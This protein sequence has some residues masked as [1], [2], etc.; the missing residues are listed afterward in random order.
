MWMKDSSENLEGFFYLPLDKING[1]LA[2]TILDKLEA[3]VCIVDIRLLKLIWT[4]KYM[5]KKL[6]YSFDELTSMTSDELLSLFH[7]DFQENL[8]ESI[9]QLN[10]KM[11]SNG[12]SVY[13]IR[14][15]DNHWI[16]IMAT[17]S[18]YENNPDG[19]YHYL[20]ASAN[21]IDIQG[22]NLHLVRLAEKIAL[23]PHEELYKLISVRERKI[24]QL[25]ANGNTDKEIAEVLNI[26]I[27]T[28]KTHRKKIIHKLG[29]KNSRTL[30][31]YAFQNGLD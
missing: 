5:S 18:V 12:P 29:L 27:H 4:N 25:I 22:L 19:S 11:D 21:E 24:L 8:V 26:S 31:K 9:R 15:K 28:A 1:N 14:T 2:N 23:N 3:F 17:S 20:L 6:G 30:I 7:S 13:K 16:W 10:G